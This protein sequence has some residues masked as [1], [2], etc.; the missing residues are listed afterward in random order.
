MDASM[1]RIYRVTKWRDRYETAESRRHKVLTWVSMPIDF[2]SNGYQSL[3]EEF[4]EDAPSIYGAWC[5][6]VAVAATTPTRGLLASSRGQAY[7]ITRIARMTCFPAAVF[8]RLIPWASRPDVG[9][10]ELVDSSQST[11]ADAELPDSTMSSSQRP[12]NNQASTGLPNQ[13]QP[14]PTQ[15][16]AAWAA[17][18]GGDFL[19]GLN[20]DEITQQANRLNEVIKGVDREFIWQTAVIGMALGRSIVDEMVV[21]FREGSIRK[22]RSYVD[23]VLRAESEKRG[24]DLI[25]LRKR[26]PPAPPPSRPKD[27]PAVVAGISVEKQSSSSLGK[28]TI[29]KFKRVDD[30]R[31]ITR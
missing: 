16:A 18:A 7:S 6:L 1:D 21:R 27:S 25:D 13:T 15:Q 10:L 5:A 29:T 2:C 11:V 31:L 14:N 3:V 9:W 4:G 20:P 12:G 24:L 28:S 23:A 17:A 26:A 8:E 19:V 30:S 22:P